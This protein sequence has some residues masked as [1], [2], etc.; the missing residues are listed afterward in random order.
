MARLPACLRAKVHWHKVKEYLEAL[1][2]YSLIA[3]ERQT[4]SY[5][6]LIPCSAPWKIPDIGCGDG[7]YLGLNPALVDIGCDRSM[8]LLQVREERVCCCCVT[9][10][11]NTSGIEGEP[12]HDFLLRRGQRPPKEVG[13][14]CGPTS[15][16][17][18]VIGFLYVAMCSMLSSVSPCCTTCLR[19]AWWLLS[20]HFF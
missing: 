6:W 11:L 19:K 18:K 14:C 17:K 3:G 16:E 10:A 8:K 9:T 1:P 12:P 5:Y 20:S 15:F 2:P 13:H 7:K 4:H